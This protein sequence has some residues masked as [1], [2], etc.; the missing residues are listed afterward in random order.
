M[1]ENILV[2]S[3]FPAPLLDRLRSYCDENDLNQS[4][5][6]RRSVSR[7]LREE[8]K[9]EKTEWLISRPRGIL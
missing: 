5:V 3:R 2:A 6:I 7:Y 9:P 8:M 4:Q 1:I